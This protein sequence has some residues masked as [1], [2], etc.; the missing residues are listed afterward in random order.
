MPTTK[1][2]YSKSILK[3]F[4]EN[5][6]K[7]S[8]SL[9][10][11][12]L[13]S[14]I[15]DC[16]NAYYNTDKPLLTDKTFDII[17][18]YLNTKSPNSKILQ[19]I[20]AVIIDVESKVKLPYYCGSMD[21]IKPGSPALKNYLK[22]YTGPYI[23]SE[24]LDG[25]SGLLKC[26]ID[27]NG[28]I[29]MN[30]YTR[31]NGL[32]GQDISHLLSFI[33]LSESKTSTQNL[34]NKL[35][36]WILS[37]STENNELI[38]RG[39]IIIKKSVFESKYTS[40]YP[41]ARSLVAGIVNS[42]ASSF[43]KQEQRA[44][45]KDIDFCLYQVVYPSNLKPEEQF[46]TISKLGLLSA[47]NEVLDLNKLILKNNFSKKGGSKDNTTVTKPET[48]TD[49]VIILKEKLL[50]FKNESQ[51]EID[52][53][54]I[55]DNSK[56]YLPN[57]SGNP[58]HAVAFKMQ[59][60]EQT[61]TTVVENVEY[62]VSKNG[63]LK[64][65]IKFKPVKIGGDTI[66]YATAFNA[67]FIKDNLLGP[68]SKIEIIR[69]GD[70]IPYINKVVSPSSNKQ[71]YQPTIEYIWNDSGVDALVKNMADAPQIISK[72][73]LH[74]FNTME[75]DGIK[76]GT[77]NRLIDS[78]F[79]TV[80]TICNLKIENLMNIEGFQVKSATKLVKNITDMKNKEYPLSL[81]MTSSNVFTNFGQKKTK[82]ATNTYNYNRIMN[83][84]PSKLTQDDLISIDGYSNKSAKLFL[85]KLPD[86]K[87][88][89][90][91]HSFLKIN[92]DNANKN[93]NTDGTQQKSKVQKV[94]PINNYN[95]VFTGFRDK[96]LE[97]KVEELGGE[98]QSGVSKNTNILVVKDKTSTSSKITKAKSLNITIKN[99]EE[100]K[101]FI[102]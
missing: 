13:E 42:K 1:T 77:I 49:P 10:L 47:R 14:F 66:M 9:T 65:R 34:K 3:E 75:V 18:D 46:K 17:V 48:S 20:G 71:W 21:K 40:K 73:I 69:S 90:K 102:N 58:K 19:Q 93:K 30:L 87:K 83:N 8:E 15:L 100:F 81:I 33:N 88:W 89:H 4:E 97:T 2:K 95:I 25:L 101:L 94:S 45:A 91:E 56:V 55:A 31:G 74:F 98:I 78:G 35:K 68:G 39:E 38:L 54:I 52:G 36:S 28:N 7:K 59:L 50:Q 22:N 63:V 85:T 32:V 37:N 96:P 43:N 99:I 11:S 5:P 24:K 23:L 67:K 72:T 86:F 70:V 27:D 53:I 79:D 57:K 84:K 64:P 29:G 82:L 62:N 61:Q 6:V 26:Y 76:I 41:K 44:I 60:D 80:K 92:K 12:E 51:Y 16:N